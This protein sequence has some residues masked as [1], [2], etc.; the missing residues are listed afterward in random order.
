LELFVRD[1]KLIVREVDPVLSSAFI[2]KDG[3]GF[4][5]ENRHTT[6]GE[7]TMGLYLRSNHSPGQTA[8]LTSEGLK[9]LESRLK[10]EL[11]ARHEKFHRE[12]RLQ[13]CVF[14]PLGRLLDQ[15][16]TRTALQE[17]FELDRAARWPLG[18]PS[19]AI[20]LRP[21]LQINTQPGSTTTVPPLDGSWTDPQSNG[22]VSADKDVGT[23]LGRSPPTRTTRTRMAARGSS[24]GWCRS[25]RTRW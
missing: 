11:Q 12:A 17:L 4:G 8:G 7:P 3:P 23:M 9:V 13:E 6:W 14:E 5:A 25:P 22:A 18:P 10:D 21:P 15:P 1:D 19:V 24:C 20:R 2:R 16:P